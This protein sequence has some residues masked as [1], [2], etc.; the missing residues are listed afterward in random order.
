MCQPNFYKCGDGISC[1]KVLFSD[2]KHFICMMLKHLHSL[3]SKNNMV[4]KRECERV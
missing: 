1:V 4:I 3:Y 2:K